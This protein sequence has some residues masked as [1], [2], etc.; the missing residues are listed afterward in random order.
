MSLLA[1]GIDTVNLSTDTNSTGANVIDLSNVS[2]ANAF[3]LKGSAGADAITGGPGADTIHGGGGIDTIIGGAGIDT[4]VSLTDVSSANGIDVITMDTVDGSA[5]TGDI[6]NFTASATFIGTTTESILIVNDT[7]VEA[8]TNA[9]GA[10]GNNIIILT[11][12]FAA[13]A[14]ALSALTF[15]GFGNLDTGQAL[16]IYSSSASA[17]ARIAVVDVAGPGDISG[18]VD[19]MTLVGVTVVEASTG[20]DAADFVLD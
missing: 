16:M 11:G 2:T 18:A 12:D 13:N 8:G 20:F 7:D 19:M 5:I 4:Y 1:A 6:F 9:F 3:T 14:G 17:N 10:A 15:D